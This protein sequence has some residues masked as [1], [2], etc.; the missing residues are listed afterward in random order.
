VAK[1]L[2]NT[3]DSVWTYLLRT[4]GR[5]LDMIDSAPEKVLKLSWT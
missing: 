5:L 1:R 4:F 2:I 3:G